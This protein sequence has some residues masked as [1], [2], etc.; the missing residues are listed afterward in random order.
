MQLFLPTITTA[1]VQ[2]RT[3]GE[4]GERWLGAFEN[5]DGE[6][7]QRQWPSEDQFVDLGN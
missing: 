7:V 4:R 3:D 6:M 5:P 2:G 1:S